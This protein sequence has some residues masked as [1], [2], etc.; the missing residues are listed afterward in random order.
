MLRGP[1]FILSINREYNPG[2]RRVAQA[3]YMESIPS[4]DFARMAQAN[5]RGGNSAEEY[6]EDLCIHTGMEPLRKHAGNVQSGG[7]QKA[8][9]SPPLAFRK[10]A[11]RHFCEIARFDCSANALHSPLGRQNARGIRFSAK[12]GSEFAAHVAAFGLKIKGLRP[13][14]NPRDFIAGI[15]FFALLKAWTKRLKTAWAGAIRRL[16]AGLVPM[17]PHGLGREGRP[18][19]STI[20]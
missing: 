11:G 2:N 4:H 20:T 10:S 17:S 14:D 19:P 8:G 6:R 13:L 3:A 5:A 16:P 15:R 1:W 7:Q 9:H 18:E 12:I